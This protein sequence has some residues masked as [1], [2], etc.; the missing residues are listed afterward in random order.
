[1]ETAIQRREEKVRLAW[2]E[3]TSAQYVMNTR[4]KNFRL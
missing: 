4:K 3:N 1:M 2:S